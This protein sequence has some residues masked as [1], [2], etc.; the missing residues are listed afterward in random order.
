MKLGVSLKSLRKDVPVALLDPESDDAL[1]AFADEASSL[2]PSQSRPRRRSLTPI[3]AALVV[4]LAGLGAGGFWLQ[5]RQAAAAATGS[6]SIQSE[7]AG[8]EVTIDGTVRG[9]TPLTISLPPGSHAMSVTGTGGRREMSVS[10]VAGQQAVHHITWAPPEAAALASATGGLTV[11][12]DTPGDV[13]LIDGTEQGRTP[14]RLE[15]LAAGAHVVSV[16]SGGSTHRRTI[17]IVPGVTTSLVISTA[18]GAGYLTVTTTLPMQVREGGQVVGSTDVRRMM[19]PP[20]DHD[21]EFV[22]EGVGFSTRRVVRIAA[23]QSTTIDVPVPTAAV[24]INATPWAEVFVDGQRIG[25]TPLANVPLPLGRHQIV[26][27]HPELGER[28]VETTATLREPTRVSVDMRS[29]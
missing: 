14:L 26:F 7:P 6:L 17:E 13:V 28:R 1:L 27:R 4:I 21:L 3:V 25:E 11:A 16:R 24:N 15:T 19:L 5:Q 10:I 20:G 22:A 12:T 23:G 18:A 8:A 29:R 9:T 2:A